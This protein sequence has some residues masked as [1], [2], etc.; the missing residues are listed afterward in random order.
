MN[1]EGKGESEKG[2]KLLLF[3]VQ[4]FNDLQNDKNTINEDIMQDK[5]YNVSNNNIH[6][7]AISFNQRKSTNYL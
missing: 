5:L 3:I 6:E 4:Q 1:G 7:V 2:N